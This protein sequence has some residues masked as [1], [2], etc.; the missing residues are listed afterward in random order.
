M[1][2]CVHVHPILMT[3]HHQ[4]SDADYLPVEVA[5][6]CAPT[7]TCWIV[8][9][10]YTFAWD[11]STI[12]KLPQPQYYHENEPISS[13]FVVEYSLL[14]SHISHL[15]SPKLQAAMLAG[16]VVAT[17]AAVVVKL[18]QIV[19]FAAQ[20]YATYNC[21]SHRRRGPSQSCPASCLCHLRCFLVSVVGSSVQFQLLWLW[22][23]SPRTSFPTTNAREQHNKHE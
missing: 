14:L 23:L 22:L 13:P 20:F 17:V 5:D 19:S 12:E 6:A 18:N 11:Y 7:T 4:N 21:E 15:T 3:L 1:Q 16:T 8:S 10:P 2:C 9:S